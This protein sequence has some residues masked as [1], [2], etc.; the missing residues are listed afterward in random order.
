M[1]ETLVNIE[2]AYAT[3][4]AQ[5][6]IELVLPVGSTVQQAIEMSGI[7]QRF[8]E[9]DLAVN[10]VGIFSQPCSLQQVLQADDRVE[11]YRP[12]VHDPKDARRARALRK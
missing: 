11:I 9:I 10:Q 2:V 7:L 5:A 3:P 12:L 8:T 6:L 1:A 4:D